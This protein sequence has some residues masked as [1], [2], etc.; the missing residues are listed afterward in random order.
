MNWFQSNRWLGG[1]LIV[2]GFCALSAL[3]CAFR[4]RW[5]FAEAS[6]RFRQAVQEQARLE[7][8]DPFPSE[9]NYRKLKVHAEDYRVALDK[10]R[11][12]LERHISPAPAIAPNEFQGRLRRA[13]LMSSERAVQNRVQLPANFRFGFDEYTSTL[14][15]NKVAPLLGQE[16]AQLEALVNILIETR[17]DLLSRLQRT[18]LAGERS[19]TTASAP[20]PAAGGAKGIERNAIDLA[21]VSSAPVAQ[22]VLN[23]IASA[24]QLFVIRMVRVRNERPNGPPREQAPAE[25]MAAKTAGNSGLTFIVGNEHVEVAARIELLRLTR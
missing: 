25:A 21:F 16:L 2:F 11:E 5:N 22:K 15:D 14:P 10:F 24:E 7:H 18:P 9:E 17:V 3:F 8:C 23:R 6:G 20:I 12:E 13:M 19:E 1:F 4:A